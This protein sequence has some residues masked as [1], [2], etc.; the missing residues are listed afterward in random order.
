MTAK[1]LRVAFCLFAC[2]LAPPGVGDL[3]AVSFDPLGYLPGYTSSVAWDVSADGS[4]VVGTSSRWNSNTDS[5]ERE[6][7][8]WTAGGGI[9]GLG[10]LPGHQSSNAT[11]VSADGSVVVGTS[12]D[13][14]DGQT[15]AFRW[16]QAEG[17][18]GLGFLPGADSSTATG[19]SDDGS[20]VVGYSGNEAFRWT[21]G[22]GM[23]GLGSLPPVPNWSPAADV[24]A[25]GSVV[26]GT[27]SFEAFR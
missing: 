19:A 10:F 26:V 15:Q 12:E 16:T 25:D 27:S 11:A 22:E 4:V 9:L 6:A 8:R 20:V 3:K 21:A 13:T 5:S 14:L 1:K 7:C 2:L 18:E 17:M 24:S 23:V